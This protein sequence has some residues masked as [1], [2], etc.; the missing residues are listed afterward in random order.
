MIFNYNSIPP[1]LSLCCTCYMLC[2]VE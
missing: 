2:R 1:L